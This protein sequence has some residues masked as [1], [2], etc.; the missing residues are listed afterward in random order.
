VEPE[1]PSKKDD[2]DGRAPLPSPSNAGKKKKSGK[3]FVPLVIPEKD[4]FPSLPKAKGNANAIPTTTDEAKPVPIRSKKLWSEM[5]TDDD[6]LSDLISSA[7]SLYQGPSTQLTTTG[8]A[9]NSAKSQA[10]KL[11][12]SEESHLFSDLLVAF[13]G[14]YHMREASRSSLKQS[15]MVNA[16]EFEMNIR[17]KKGKDY[18][19]SRPEPLDGDIS[20]SKTL[21]ATHDIGQIVDWEIAS[22]IRDAKCCILE[23]SYFQKTESRDSSQTIATALAYYIATCRTTQCVDRKS[24]ED[25]LSN[26]KFTLER[27]QLSNAY[28]LGMNESEKFIEPMIRSRKTQTDKSLTLRK[29][30][31][32]GET[33]K[34]RPYPP[35][36]DKLLVFI[37]SKVMVC[38]KETL[39]ESEFSEQA[40]TGFDDT[41][42]FY[43][44]FIIEFIKRNV[45]WS[46]PQSFSS[47]T[48]LSELENYLGIR[49]PDAQSR[50][51]FMTLSAILVRCRDAYSKFGASN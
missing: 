4:E 9:S 11:S 1:A 46:K 47:G 33:Q 30:R 26:V 23:S 43:Q 31:Q 50:Q 38:V 2:T 45:N 49:V 25:V 51:V 32:P 6:N 44:K 35:I 40:I 14:I 18:R 3:K 48:K 36:E 13:K 29:N 37:D 7:Q 16:I 39:S 12:S 21:H 41:S 17:Q 15:K 28:K 20:I 19:S 22:A 34:S 10:T 27:H 42:K 8:N 5:D 24:I